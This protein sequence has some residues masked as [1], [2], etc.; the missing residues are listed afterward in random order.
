[1]WEC[2]KSSYLCRLT[3]SSN[4]GHPWPSH[5][6]ELRTWVR[7]MERQ[8]LPLETVPSFSGFSLPPELLSLLTVSATLRIPL[9]F[10]HTAQLTVL[11]LCCFCCGFQEIQ[12]FKKK[13]KRQTALYYNYQNLYSS[14]FLSFNVFCSKGK[15]SVPQTLTPFLATMPKIAPS[16]PII[17]TLVLEK[18]VESPSDCKEIQPVHPKG[19]QSWVFIQRTDA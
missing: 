5:I 17:R 8:A 14:Y 9:L 2:W 11:A 10:I 13:K 16:P 19:D 12:K 1:M 15:L 3:R 18:A 7:A 4:H 6:L